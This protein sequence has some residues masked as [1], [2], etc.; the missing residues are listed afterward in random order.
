[1]PL[2][3]LIVSFVAAVPVVGQDYHFSHFAGTTG[4]AGIIDANGTAAYLA[5]PQAIARGADG[6]LYIT[7]YRSSTIRVVSPGG[8]V[9]T[10]AGLAGQTTPADGIRAAARF[11]FPWGIARDNSG[12]LY[13]TESSH[14]IRKITP[15]GVVTTLAGTFFAS[16][17]GN[18]TGSGATFSN[19]KGIALDPTTGNLYVADSGNHVIRRVTP[20]GVVTTFT[21]VVGSAGSENGPTPSPTRFNSPTGIAV[22][23]SGNVYV[24]DANHMIRKI[25]PAGVA[26]TLAGSAG[27]LGYEDLSGTAARFRFP[28]GLA[29]DSGGNVYVGDIGNQAVRLITSGGATSTLAGGA[30]F[31]YQDGTGASAIF[32]NP[33]GVAVDGSGTVYVVDRENHT[34]RQVTSGGV[35][36][37]IAGAGLPRGSTNATGSNARFFGPHGMAIDSSGNIFVV[38]RHN[39]LIRKMTSGAVVTT[40]AGSIPGALDATGTNARFRYPTGLVIDASNNLY[41]A[42]QQ[43][44]TIRKITPG[45]VVTTLAGTAGS[46]GTTNATGD[47]ARFNN[48][49]GVA[50]D[51]AA[52]V[53]VADSSNHAIRKITSAGVVTTFAGLAGTSGALNHNTG[54]SARFNNPLDIAR[55]PSTG[56]FYVADRNNYAIRKITSAGVVTTFAGQMG[57]FGY[58]DATGGD[59]RFLEPSAVKTD[60]SGNVFVV[61]RT[62]IRK[63]TPEGVVTTV[64]GSDI[65]RGH[66]NATGPFA[67]FSLPGSLA[68]DSSGGLFVSDVENHSISRGLP[69]LGVSA[70]IDA[71][72]GPVFQPRTLSTSST[73]VGM[74]FSWALIRRPTGSTATL[75]SPSARSPSFTPDLPDVYVFRLTA[76]Y[77]GNTSITDVTLSVTCPAITI[78]PTSL[79]HPFIGVAYS[80]G[81]SCGGGIGACTFSTLSGAV[82]PGLALAANGTLSGTAT[83][84]G[85]YTFTVLA[86]DS[87]GCT[88]SRSYT[89]TAGT[90][91]APA[92]LVAT[93]SA[94]GSGS[95]VNL[96]WSVVPGATGYRIYRMSWT[97]PWT[98]AGS[99]ASTSFN[100]VPPADNIAFLYKVRAYDGSLIESADSNLDFANTYGDLTAV[101]GSTLIEAWHVYSLRTIITHMGYIT[102]RPGF[103]F[104]DPNPPGLPVKA[105]HM[106]EMRAELNACRVAAGLSTLSF[107]DPSL[108]GVVIKAIHINE[109]FAGVR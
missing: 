10:L 83:T 63:I 29:V 90:L 55:D 13:V 58:V 23:S 54:T 95:P 100:D 104:T 107:T 3:S 59:A 71:P 70:T 96:T 102:G 48:P 33:C 93:W 53:Y 75:S 81:I 17:S 69:A 82:P 18:G 41:V 101:A 14:V 8:A 57:S 49:N 47:L 27:M 45:A 20:G 43:N 103:A 31:G 62:R 105:I 91:A 38:D 34:V 56:N 64:G 24:S 86:T 5:A 92:G 39:S 22:D 85:T 44:H 16:G 46:S 88:G 97:Y 1:V 40:F 79:P 66:E 2:I 30:A 74:S 6:T 51:A 12:N 7:D 42:E 60:S 26:T 68:V 89:L 67:R 61:D 4:G 15:I 108:T 25:T 19:P 87:A 52:N 73:T 94:L 84:P 78:G 72:T 76:Q 65:V 50:V 35:V 9:T 80:Q 109:L 11:S 37:T 98:L 32:S 99:S 36:T 21:G 77:L 106:N 28:D